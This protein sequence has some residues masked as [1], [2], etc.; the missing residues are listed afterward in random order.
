MNVSICSKSQNCYTGSVITTFL[1][2]GFPWRLLCEL[3]THRQITKNAESSRARP[4]HSV[5]EQVLADPYI[6][7]WTKA[8]KGMQ[9]SPF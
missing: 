4:T 1:L 9:G 6:P 8:Q 7:V 3:N 2:E 5:I